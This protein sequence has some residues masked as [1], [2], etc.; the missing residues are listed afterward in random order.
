LN[1]KIQPW[2]R[3]IQ[4]AQE[5]I[6][7]VKWLEHNACNLNEVCFYFLKGCQTALPVIYFKSQVKLFRPRNMGQKFAIFHKQ[8]ALNI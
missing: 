6:E 7:G 2:I 8:N 1:F 5:V 3:G 4:L